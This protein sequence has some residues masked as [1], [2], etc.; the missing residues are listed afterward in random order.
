MDEYHYGVGRIRSLEAR[1]LTPSQL[2]RMAAAADFEESF[3]VLSE[4]TYSD[5]LPKLKEPFDFEELCELELL[6]LKELMDHLALNHRD[7]GLAPGSEILNA[8]FRKYDY[9]NLKILIRSYFSQKKE[10][11]LPARAGTVGFDNLRLYVFE[12]MDEVDN[13]EILEAIDAAKSSYEQNRDPLRLDIILDKHY[14]SRLKQRVGASPS[15]LI[16]NLVDHQID[17][18]NIKTVLRAQELKKDKEFLGTVLLDPG[19]IDKDILVDL[20]DKNPQDIILRLSFTPYFPGIAEGIEYYAKNRS[21]YLLEKLMD[22]YV[23]DQFRKAKYISSGIEPLVGFCLAKESEV[24]TLRFILISKKNYI[25]SEQI[26]ER[27]RA[28]YV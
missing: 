18:N 19:L 13:Q 14:F 28:S 15:P 7:S 11:E 9:L 5:N 25:E 26:K 20:H 23:I 8:L 12:G 6:S 2:A 21:F 10:I 22:N 17:L 3:G 24:K 27:L 16:Q 1:M 4:T